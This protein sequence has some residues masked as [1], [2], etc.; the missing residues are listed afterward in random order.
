MSRVIDEQREQLEQ[1]RKERDAS[2]QRL[3]S[4]R[5]DILYFFVCLVIFRSKETD[6]A[7]LEEEYIALSSKCEKAKEEANKT[8]EKIKWKMVRRDYI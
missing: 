7:R 4:G 2:K 5:Q 8:K 1:L 3:E 6:I